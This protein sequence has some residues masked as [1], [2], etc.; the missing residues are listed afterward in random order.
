MDLSS[1]QVF[2]HFRVSNYFTV[3]TPITGMT[4]SMSFYSDMRFRFITQSLTEKCPDPP[5]RT[6]A[7]KASIGSKIFSSFIGFLES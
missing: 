7:E 1:K 2:S 6:P 4:L 3:F 5:L